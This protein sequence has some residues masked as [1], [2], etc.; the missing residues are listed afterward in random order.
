[1]RYVTLATVDD[2]YH[3]QSLNE[4]LAEAD[5]RCIEANETINTLLPHLRQGIQIRVKETDYIRAKIIC[6]K[7]E[8]TR[9]LR[10]PDCESRK[11]TYSGSELKELTFVT[12]LLSLLLSA[13]I[14][15]NVL[16][17][18]CDDCGATFKIK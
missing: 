1:M 5:I 10:C 13:P 9:M 14:K 12:T 2:I 16:I 6:D 17:Y 15:K 3:A 18:S 7:I 11:V 8:E 4:A